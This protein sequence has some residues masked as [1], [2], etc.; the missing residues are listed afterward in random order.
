M[1]EVWGPDTQPSPAL[2]NQTKGLQSPRNFYRFSI[3]PPS[4]LF[5][6]FLNNWVTEPN[7]W[8]I[9]SFERTEARIQEC[10]THVNTCETR[11]YE[12]RVNTLKHK[13]LKHTHWNV[14]LY[15]IFNNLNQYARNKLSKKNAES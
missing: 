12:T 15:E 4:F 5:D 9:N 13:N 14:K 3:T 6:L 10:E 11:E 1:V 2:I 8:H 7:W